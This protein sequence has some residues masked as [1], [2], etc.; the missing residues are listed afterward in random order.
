MSVSEGFDFESLDLGPAVRPRRRAPDGLTRALVVALGLALAFSAGVRA[1][2][3]SRPSPPAAV[4]AGGSPAAG[5]PPPGPGVAV[6]GRLSVVDGDVLYVTDAEGRTVKVVV[7]DEAKLSTVRPASRADLH[8]GD[9]VVV[10]GRPA[11]EGTISA[12][13]ITNDYSH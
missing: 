8:V 10:E 6:S 5:Q 3:G 12:I 9:T 4:S 13:S 11:P 2:R 1:G 7:T